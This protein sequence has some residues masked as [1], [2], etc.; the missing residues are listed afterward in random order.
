ME[1]SSSS[2]FQEL[3]EKSRAGDDSADGQLFVFLYDD[4]RKLARNML[5]S[6]RPGHS[7]QATA[8]VHEAFLRLSSAKAIE[9]QDKQH[10]LALA[11]RVMRRLLVDRARRKQAQKRGRVEAIDE[12]DELEISSAAPMESILDLDRALSKLE[13]VSARTARIVEWRYLVGLSIEEIANL[14]GVSGRTVLRDIE[15]ARCF[16]ADVLDLPE[17]L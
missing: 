7:V 11:G 15:M 17:R 5:K 13:L 9:P 4:L 12:A 1:A 2:I 14:L 10:Y 3:L 16:L 8:L 6:E